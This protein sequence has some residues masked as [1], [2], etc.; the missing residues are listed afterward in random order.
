MDYS[1][2]YFEVG[3][4]TPTLSELQVF[5]E[6]SEVINGYEFTFRIIGS[7]HYISGPRNYTEVAACK[8]ITDNNGHEFSMNDPINSTIH[9]GAETL[10]A[11]TKIESHSLSEFDSDREYTLSYKFGKDAYTAIEITENGYTTYHT[12]PE[13]ETLLW[14]HTLIKEPGS[15]D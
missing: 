3:T 15:N 11:R 8:Q 9:A 1:T 5:A 6:S 12:Y 2:L 4:K 14:T 7:S 10:D 13:F